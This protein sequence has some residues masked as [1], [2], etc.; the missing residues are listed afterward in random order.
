LGLLTLAAALRLYRLAELPPGFHI[1]EAYNMLDALRIV[2]GERPVFLEANAGRD[3]LYSYF[4]AVLVVLL[5]P[6]VFSLR[7]T[8]ALIGI[9]TVG[10]TYGF[11][12]GLPLRRM[13]ALLTA[14]LL[15]TSFWHLAFSRFG[16]RAITLPFI[17]VLT[18]WFFW[19]GV[20]A[21]RLRDFALSGLFLGLG[22]YTHPA[23]R[24]MPIIPLLFIVYLAVRYRTSATTYLRGLVLMALVAVIVFL[25]LG[26]Y[27][28]T[29]PWAFLGHPEEVSILSGRVGPGES[30]VHL[31]L[32][33][34]WRVLGM[35]TWEG[36][37]AWWRNLAG[38]PVFD[39][40]MGLAFVV[41]LGLLLS[42][43]F[44]RRRTEA[45]RDVAVFALLWLGVMLLP[46]WLTDQ[47][48][49]FSRAIGILPIVL[50][51][52]AWALTMA[53]E[54]GAERWGR[55]AGAGLGIVVLL[56]AAWTAGDYFVV[57][58]RSPE[59]YYAFDQDKVDIAAYIH[60]VA[61]QDRV[62][63]APFLAE[64][65]TVRF[66]TRDV[67]LASFDISQGLV[68]PPREGD[69]G[70]RYAFW[71]RQPEPAAETTLAGLAE[72]EVVP[73]AQGNPMLILYQIP[74][75]RLPAAEAPLATLPG[76]LGPLQP[77][78]TRFG[79]VIELVGYEVEGDLVAGGKPVLTLVWRGLRPVGQNYTVFV[80]VVD[81]SGKR[82][83]QHDKQPLGG[84]YPTSIWAPGEVVIDR[85]PL[86]I[87]SDAPGLL[88]LWVGLYLLETG[89]RLPVA[90][91]DETF[92]ELGR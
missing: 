20:Q 66:L 52:P 60:E 82:W 56:S 10:L 85:Y 3:V 55:W 43:A 29:H 34:A 87:A 74:A 68:L 64:H 11:V 83:G 30:R 92:V 73:D 86:A 71:A 31:L 16:I 8:S 14:L 91:S 61:M 22:A 7:L 4:Q 63:P 1:D 77:V 39:P 72:K 13:T 6:Q 67:E 62:Y 44:V 78:G 36:D 33:N 89:E 46:T 17:E 26:G 88:R 23:G 59:L 75:Q 41:G 35:F 2:N 53:W 81:E 47:A 5:G 42:L 25:P 9:A 38:R 37:G 18:F 28:W 65:P 45:Q 57:Y 19:Q 49:N 40:L 27:F 15:A 54:W 24:L 32:T 84:S 69:R 50:L 21:G 58:A 76:D 12:R 51:P 48:P 80:H 90:G 70:A 79:E